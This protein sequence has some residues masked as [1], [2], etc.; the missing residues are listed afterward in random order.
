MEIDQAV[1]GQEGV[2]KFSQSAPGEYS[3]ILM[4]LRMPLLDGYGAT[5]AIREL[6]RK[7]AKTIPIIAMTADVFADDIQKCLDTGMNDHVAK[8][9]DPQ[10][11]I[12]Y[13]G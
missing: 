9:I 2:E 10:D 8:P 12:C 13:P 4:D 6:N 5:K 3:A 1:N 11:F 7:D